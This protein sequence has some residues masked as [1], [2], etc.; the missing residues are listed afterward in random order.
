M[1]ESLLIEIGTE[2]L[3]AIPFLK[4]LPYIKEKW[5]KILKDNSLLANF[6]FDYTPRRLVLTSN[7]FLLKQPD[8][9]QE[10]F[11][12][13]VG[14]AYKDGQPTNAALGFAKKCG[15]DIGKIT[16][17]TKNSK[18]VL[19]F[20]K[21]V[22]GK[23]SKELLPLMITQFL[24]DLNFGK[25][26]RWGECDE[27]FIRPIR[28]IG[29]MLG[30]EVIH[31]NMY[32]QESQNL[33]Y[34]HRTHTY[35]PLSYDSIAS[36][37]KLLKKQSVILNADERRE[38]IL[39][40]FRDIQKNKNVTIQVDQELLD[41]V[42]AITEYP[43]ALFGS[44]D[45]SFLKLP[46]EVIIVSM[47]EHQRYFPIYKDQKLSNHF[48]F[49]SNAYTDDYSK[50]IKGNEKVLHPRLSDALFFYENDLKNGLD[51]E[52]LK[53]VSFMQGLGS[54]YDKSQRES[55]IANYLC[56][57]Y[58]KDENEKKLI[59]RAVMYAKSDLLTD[60]VYEFTE[61]QGVMG[62]YYA[63]EVKE[64][65]NIAIS[66]KEQYLPDGDQ[67]KLPSNDFS[68][69]VALSYK[70]DT[71]L[72]LFSQ[73]KI[74]TGTKDPYALRRAAVGIVKIVLDRGF[75]FDIYADLKAL[76][77]L[78][79]DF[80]FKL[81]ERFFLE[82]LSHFFD[83]NTSVIG[84]VL[85]TK[86]RDI[87]EISKKIEALNQIVQ[88]EDFKESFVTFK[89]VANI[90]K[91][92]EQNESISIDRELFEHKEE[93]IL[94]EKYQNIASKEYK[95]YTEKLEA[96]FGLKGEIDKFFD[97]VLVNAKDEKIKNNRKNL[98]ALIYQS[99]KDIADIKE[100]TI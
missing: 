13:P 87:I 71:I 65:E 78:Y 9:I 2:E 1:R 30:D 97:N 69:I 28:W 91:D 39:S 96:L 24:K 38:R 63:K 17:T 76:T 36:Y 35:K 25:S 88:K 29:C 86:E 26:M 60:M 92:I 45:K 64:D 61:L 90:I 51:N 4:E 95:N 79:S 8:T 77:N 47:K 41:E 72:A 89:R 85:K 53:K 100:I 33:T 75:S 52:G 15:I 50:I 49:V 46:P 16:T 23:S 83:A 22:F 59:N 70:I 54:I 67:S 19:Y 5:I 80:E 20:Q 40:Q 44:F 62:Y 27:S 58:K 94:F 37:H 18:E 73:G 12:A 6:K 56:E 14:I 98:I 21:R 68:A 93:S 3:P 84:A 7:D 34:G 82:R 31:F 99:F 11:G 42:V 10:L 48:V 57:L 55:K 81:L 32:G 66:Y 74:P 43:T